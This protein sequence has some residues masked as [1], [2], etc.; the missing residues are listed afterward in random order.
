MGMVMGM[1][2]KYPGGRTRNRGTGFAVI[3]LGPLSFQPEP[4][5]WGGVHRQI[6]RH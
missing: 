3:G 6:N 1:C 2:T 4:V 5:V